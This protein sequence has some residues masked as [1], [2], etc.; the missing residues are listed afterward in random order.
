MKIDGRQIALT[1]G[2]PMFDRPRPTGQIHT[3][4]VDAFMTRF[5]RI[6]EGRR[7]SNGGP[8]QEELEGR[9]ADWHRVDHVVAF[10]NA[11][12]ALIALMRHLARPDAGHVLLPSFSYRGLPHFVQWAGKTPRF[13]DVDERTHGLTAAT[14]S[15]LAVGGE[16]AAILSVNNVNG[17]SDLAGLDR[18]AQDLGVPLI[19]DSVYAIAAEWNEA[20]FGRHGAAE[21]FSLHATKLVN[22]F[23]GGYITTNDP[24]LAES[25]RNIR[26]FGYDTASPH[27]LHLGMNGKLNELHAA[28]ALTSLDEIDLALAHN[29][30]IIAA[31]RAVVGDDAGVRIVQPEPGM[32]SNDEMVLLEVDD[33]HELGRDGFLL[34]LQAEGAHARPYFDPPLH[35]SKNCPPAAAGAELPVSDRLATRFAQLPTGAFVNRA[36]ATAIAHLIVEL[37]RRAGE[38]ARAVPAE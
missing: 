26:N 23:E 10:G 30:E 18:L 35:R 5:D 28:M 4:D 31:Y 16:V 19:H 9:L 13:C 29:R 1:G 6:L 20:P 17:P 37:D 24:A 11:C 36:D 27:I 38:A 12:F 2:T 14:A 22:G 34:A 15:D 3:P 32:V 8:F 25:M 21:V 33:G 7:Y